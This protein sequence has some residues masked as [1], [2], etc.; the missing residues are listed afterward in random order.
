MNK[1]QI[2]GIITFFIL[3]LSIYIYKDANLVL[4]K[5]NDTPY[6][7]Q[8]NNKTVGYDKGKKVFEIGINNV[9]QQNY[10][11]IL[12]AKDITKG[13][14]YNHK[15]HPVIRQL[16]GDSARINT[17]IKSIVV[18]EN[19]SAIIEPSTSS[20][21]I[22]VKAGKF[23]YNHQNKIAE[24]MRDTELYVKKIRIHSNQFNYSNSDEILSF[25]NGLELTENNSKTVAKNAILDTVKSTIIATK[26]IVTT[27]TK[28][29]TNKDSD[30]IKELLKHETIITSEKLNIN[31]KDTD[32]TIITYGKNVL[33]KQPGK[34]LACNELILNFKK[35]QYT[36]K[37]NIQLIFN[38]LDWLLNKKRI[39]KNKSIQSLLRKET[40]IMA[41]T[42]EF[43]P[44]NNTLTLTNN[45]VLKQTNLKLQGDQ[46]IYDINNEKIKI[47]GNVIVKKY[48]MEYFNSNKLVID[49]KNETFRTDSKNALSEITLELDK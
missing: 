39:L 4:E 2:S 23:K 15:E 17:N 18:T 1:S 40:T 35:D 11:H 8:I 32:H 48:G 41:E 12:F 38:N 34:T 5:T 22:V 46:L 43:S 31:F 13:S 37:G 27:Y 24:F 20:Q 26:N 10:Q 47:F 19:I 33:A 9:L 7:K 21:S 3:I 16:K 28:K 36:A 14:V 29:E 30:Q 49:I 25:K 45:V 42:G 6:V 44:S